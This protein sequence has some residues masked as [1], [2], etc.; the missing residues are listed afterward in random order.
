MREE[1]RLSTT[2]FRRVERAIRFL[3]EHASDQPGLRTVAGVVG[4]SEYHFQ[5]L[6][7]RWAGVSPKRFLQFLTADRAARDLRSASTSLE[8]SFRSG[9]SSPSRLHDLMVAVN[10]VTPGEMKSGGAGVTIR[11]GIQPTPFGD[12]LLA[13]TARGICEMAFLAPDG[14]EWSRE[15]LRARWPAAELVRHEATAAE[16]TGRIFSRARG[17]RPLML[18]LRGTNFQLQVWRALLEIPQGLTTTYGALATSIGAP[19]AARAVGGAIGAHPIAY[20]IPCHRVIRATGAFGGYRW[21]VDRKRALLAWDRA[22]A[23]SGVT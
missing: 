2:D 12:C 9:L 23:E 6:F 19:G 1:H 13:T 4:M 21:G 15:R 10:A 20:P 3:D 18:L 8:A 14:E 11:W 5:R 17:D 22:L 7:R 16:L